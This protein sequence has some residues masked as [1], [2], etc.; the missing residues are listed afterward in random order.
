MNNENYFIHNL[1]TEKLNIHTTKE[2]YRGL[3]DE[4]KKVI[5][6][7]CLWSRSGNCWVSK[8]K[9]DNCYYLAK[10][11]LDLGFENRGKNGERISFSEKVE[12]QQERAENKADRA[13]ERAIKADHNGDALYARAKGMADHIPFG[14]PILVGHH[15]EKR[16]RNF[17]NQIHNTFGKAFSE[18]DKAKYYTE[19]A[20]GLRATASGA[21]YSNPAYLG[22]RIAEAE[23]ELRRF[24]RSLNGQS[25][26]NS[27]KR[28]ISEARREYLNDK[29]A[30][31][32][33][34]LDFYKHCLETCGIKI[35][36]KEDLKG[37]K[38]IKIRNSWREI[39]KLNRLTVSVY[40]ELFP[41]RNTQARWAQKYE[42]SEIMES[43]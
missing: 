9:A 35:F 4:K 1:E 17:R 20:A 19:K 32:T 21:I 36:T 29:I 14:Q 42:Y 40:N 3:S 7:F 43:K 5:K 38:F 28:E 8:G 2:F 22:R 18:M 12:R 37:V 26:V 10:G 31:K 24:N 6:N 11:L 34:E 33:D 16:D 25:S 23:T 39:L 30:V 13:D 15:S 41:D 27:P